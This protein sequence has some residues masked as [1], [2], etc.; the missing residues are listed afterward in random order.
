MILPLFESGLESE[1]EFTVYFALFM[2]VAIEAVRLII[3]G[4]GGPTPRPGLGS[5]P[6]DGV[7]GGESGPILGSGPQDGIAGGES[8]PGEALTVVRVRRRWRGFWL[9]L[10]LGFGALA[11][12]LGV[13]GIL[14]YDAAYGEDFGV[15]ALGVVAAVVGVRASTG[16]G[17]RLTPRASM[18]STSCAGTR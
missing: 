17:S 18:S 4:F 8:G 13:Q 16:S 10:F 7:P 12:F 9:A 5:G 2:V 3:G 11:T 15:V 1:L 14:L 6:Q